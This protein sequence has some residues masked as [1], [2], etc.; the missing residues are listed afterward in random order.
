MLDDNKLQCIQLIVKGESKTEIAK[1]IKVSRK[2]I[3]NWIEDEE[4]K[5]ELSEMREE[6]KNRAKEIIN[7]E[8]VKA[9]KIVVDLMQKAKSE[10]VRYGAA[11]DI[12]DRGLGKATSRME[13]SDSREG[14]DDV[15]VDVLDQEIKE[16]DNE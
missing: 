11:S 14:E 6:S 5:K 8:A 9:A 15:S 12:L 7:N 16:I 10:K 13:L 2:T 4:F 3:Y 1:L